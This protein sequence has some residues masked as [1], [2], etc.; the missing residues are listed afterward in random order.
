MY[1]CIIAAPKQKMIVHDRV[2]TKA[3]SYPATR[4]DKAKIDL[5]VLLAA[6]ME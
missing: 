1:A 6:V 3:D 2:I 5:L 4:Q